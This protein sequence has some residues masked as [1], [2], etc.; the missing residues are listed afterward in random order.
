M[1]ENK[2]HQG[3]SSFPFDTDSDEASSP[4]IDAPGADTPRDDPA[5]TSGS[6]GAG[7]NGGES[8]LI[9][10]ILH[11]AVSASL[12]AVAAFFT[13]WFLITNPDL[14][15]IF[16]SL[17][18]KFYPGAVPF[19]W[20][21]LVW[22][23]GAIV[24]FTVVGWFF[25]EC[26]EVYLPRAALFTLAF[27]LGMG[28]AGFAFE[29][30]AMARLL[31]RPL[32]FLAPALLILAMW[33]FTVF[34]SRREPQ[35]GEGG[36]GGAVEQSMRRQMARQGY[37]RTLV[38]P[39]TFAGRSFA[40]VA[41]GLIA[42]ITLTTFYHALLY[43][44]TYWDSLILYLGYARMMFYEK[45]IVEKVVGQVGIGLGANYPHMY[46]LLGTAISLAAREWSDLPQRLL[47]PAA[48]LASTILVY[49]MI[50]RLTRHVN[51][52]LAL[53]LL[54]RAIPLG[55]AY[56]Q[57]ASDYALAIAFTAAFLYVAQLYI[58]TGLRGYF[59]LATLIV[60]LAMH[61]NYL[62]GIMWLPWGGMI[63]A[64]HL[65][66][67]TYRD[68]QE[69]D[70]ARD[71]SL[72]HA[73]PWA[74][75]EG[76]VQSEPPWVRLATRQGLFRFLASPAFIVTSI[77][78]GVVASTWL[79]RNQIVTGNP[80]Y[81]FFHEQLGGKF[82]NPEVMKSAEREWASNGAGIGRFGNTLGERVAGSWTF[83]TGYYQKTDGSAGHW[84][85]GFRLSP[86]FL[87][88]VL[89]GMLLLL[90]R[91]A[92]APFIFGLFR[93]G[94]WRTAD[95]GARFGLVALSLGLALLAFHYV[96]ATF[97]LY[98]IISILPVMAV[99]AGF[100]YPYWRRRGW[101]HAF[102]ALVIVIGLVPGVAMGL[103][104]FKVFGKV[105]IGPGRFETPFDLFAFRHPLPEP[106]KFYGWRY[107]D[108]A[109]MWRYINLNLKGEKILT[110]ENRH[111]VFDPSIT[112]IQLDDWVVQQMWDE[113]AP[114]R[115]EDLLTLGVRYYLKVPNE[116]AH[117][118]NNRMETDRWPML[119]LAELVYEAGE[120]RLYRLISP[121]TV[122]DPPEWQEP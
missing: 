60:A 10:S 103:M 62:M 95:P 34:A 40:G 35:S 18:L 110:H 86:F 70:Y 90:A 11:H 43:P 75:G 42:V 32:V 23:L 67:P 51:Y 7:G 15:Q 100:A 31:I 71:I 92:A 118:I 50:L 91:A 53:T 65:F 105:K 69:A 96:L 6:S 30:L 97:Y 106:H 21:K 28:L 45:G 24:I 114:E 121:S 46:S 79:L 25:I 63:V 3:E 1:T 44:E 66:M 14:F 22:S 5:S 16:P 39:V 115:V 55:I 4:L 58:E 108:D 52:S 77:A 117:T 98:Q 84:T 83:F 72:A 29:L 56:N 37:A 74:L 33:P 89:P 80:V 57:Y 99:V 82:I 112:L 9:S 116:A 20:D 48:G 12:F 47:A 36:E 94:P 111:L 122:G 101:R 76:S 26:L 49:H 73:K 8:G 109:D 68:E 85:N 102:G 2:G 38:R 93:R 107:G 78:C 27:I 13:L 19:E 119:K 87:G 81:A 113:P 17:L 104:G 54:Y 64:A 59:I 88:F 120:N 41:L 61:L